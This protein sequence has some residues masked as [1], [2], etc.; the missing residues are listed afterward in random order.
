M[1][2]KEKRTI[3]SSQSS[4]TDR[5]WGEPGTMDGRKW[6]WRTWRKASM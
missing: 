6:S 5:I 2:Q 4:E 1:M 3:G